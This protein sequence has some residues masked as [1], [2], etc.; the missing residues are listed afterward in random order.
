MGV[1]EQSKQL[2]NGPVGLFSALNLAVFIQ[3]TFP[4]TKPFSHIAFK[5]GST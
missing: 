5:N 3:G 4:L 1:C 2:L